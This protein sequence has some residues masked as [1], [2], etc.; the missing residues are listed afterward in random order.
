MKKAV[1]ITAI[2]VLMALLS[3]L[4]VGCAGHRITIEKISPEKIIADDNFLQED[5]DRFMAKIA[6]GDI[7]ARETISDT[8][9]YVIKSWARDRE[10]LWNIAARR[11]GNPQRWYEIY[12]I[13][14][15]RIGIN[16]DLIIEG[17]TLC[18]PVL[19][20]DKK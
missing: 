16:P 7:V 14:A 8:E 18:L 11:Y 10:C 17:E 13:N 1:S 20:I 2:M 6:R 5:A 15:D 3:F 4:M 12:A 19:S 9:N